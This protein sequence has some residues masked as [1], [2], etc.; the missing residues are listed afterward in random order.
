V[1]DYEDGRPG[2]RADQARLLFDSQR[3]TLA[4]RLRGLRKNQLAEA[5]GTTP[6]AIG[7]YEAGVHRPSATTL[8]RLAIALGVPVEFF[9]AGRGRAVLDSAHA[10]F[11][12]LRSTTQIERD[13]AL[14]YGRIAGDI[15]AALE[16]VVE[17]PPVDVP[18]YPVHPDEMAGPGPVR[19]ARVARAALAATPG[20][21]AHV[22]RLLESR[23]IVVIVLPPTPGRW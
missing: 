19:A 11:R 20:P 9:H 2:G 18:E 7:Q 17:F 6:T 22:V 10:H 5:I 3:L 12:S 4:R 13:Q 15:V 8:S 14:A 1:S 21:I 16:A 23:G